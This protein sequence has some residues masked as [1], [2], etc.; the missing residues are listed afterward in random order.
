MRIIVVGGCG[1]IGT[2]LVPYL[3]SDG[4]K[5]TVFDNFRFKQTPHLDSCANPNFSII[6]GDCRDHNAILPI[7]KDHEIVIHLA[8]IVGVAACKASPLD[9]DSIN[10]GSTKLLVNNMSKDQI[11][12][13]PCTNSGYG[14]GQEGI[15]CTE[16]SP[17]RPIS[18]YGTTKVAAEKIVMQR[19][20]SISFRLAT[21]FGASPCFRSELLVN[22]FV[23]KAVF[24]KSVNLF[25]PHFKR[26]YI[27]VRD[28]AGAFLLGIKQFDSMKSN[29]YNVGLSS[30]NL[31]KMELCDVIKK[32]LDFDIIINEGMKD[33]DQRNYMVSNKKIERCGFSPRYSLDDGIEELIKAY[34][35]TQHSY[36]SR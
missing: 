12:L 25:E 24:D 13:F 17:L 34:R 31:S 36:Y 18:I 32:H 27:H 4:H 1:Y 19:E 14:I 11:L 15:Y 30:A 33:D 20:N 35:I 22:D 10:V 26:N 5:V 2:I 23:R 9:A 7:L 3:L 21:V 6:A 8:A 29:V 28:V 16:E